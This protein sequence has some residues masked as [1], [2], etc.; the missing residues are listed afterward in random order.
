MIPTSLFSKI[1]K[2][3][4]WKTD[5]CS[6]CGSD[7]DL[8]RDHVIPDWFRSKVHNFGFRIHTGKSTFPNYQ[9]YQTLCKECNL[10]KGGKIDWSNEVV[11][12]YMRKFANNILAVLDN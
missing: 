2:S 5:I 12:E 11:R 4:N 6:K 10:K 1:E 9:K 7:K 8:T 3:M